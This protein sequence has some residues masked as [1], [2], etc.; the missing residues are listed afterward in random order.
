MSRKFVDRFLPFYGFENKFNGFSWIFL[1][2]K[3]F[4]GRLNLL[5]F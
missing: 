5:D 2:K 1:V 4:I 3:K